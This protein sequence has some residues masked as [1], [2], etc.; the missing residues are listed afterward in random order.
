[1][2]GDGIDWS[3]FA[4]FAAQEMPPGEGEGDLQRNIKDALPGIEKPRL[5]DCGCNIARFAPSLV[6][7]GFDYT[8]IDQS[9]EAVRIS[10]IRYPNLKFDVAFLW[11]D[12]PSRFSPFDCAMCNAVLQHNT[13]D[14][15]RRILP[16]IAQ[17]VRIG[18]IFG[19]QESTVLEET[20]TQFRQDQWISFVESYGFK[21]IKQWH[22][23][24]LDID[25]GYLF[26]R[27]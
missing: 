5:V 4:R 8:G 27:I 6:K 13:H 17:A 18:G 12:W 19:M 15:K 23:N 3:E 22:R 16:R 14:E 26:R 21:L 20:K 7:I 11:E 24:E 10:R 1:M 9:E 2:F 25:D